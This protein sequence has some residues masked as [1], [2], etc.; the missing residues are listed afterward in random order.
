MSK[1]TIISAFLVTFALGGA[2]AGESLIPHKF[3]KDRFNEAVWESECIMGMKSE[4]TFRRQD[5]GVVN[6][7]LS[8]YKDSNC[9]GTPFIVYQNSNTYKYY[10]QRVEKDSWGY[11]RNIPATYHFQR[12]IISETRNGILVE[13]LGV[14]VSYYSECV[15]KS[16]KDTNLQTCRIHNFD[17]STIIIQADRISFLNPN[18][19]LVQLDKKIKA[20][21]FNLK[22]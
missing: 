8:A 2:F 10:P 15:E 3:I 9:Q 7:S 6:I 22:K 14:S 18:S 12:G 1:L 21:R 4:M 20:I 17:Q 19:F 11:E 5:P 16:A 13:I